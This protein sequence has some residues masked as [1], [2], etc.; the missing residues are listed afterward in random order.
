MI[1]GYRLCTRS[2]VISLVL[3]TTKKSGRGM[4]RGSTKIRKY[5]HIYTIT[6]RALCTLF[7]PHL[8]LVF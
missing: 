2:L 6:L 5:M 7:V 3:R 1:H 8:H 4:Y